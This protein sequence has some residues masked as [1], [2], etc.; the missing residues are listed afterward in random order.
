MKLKEM[1][2]PQETVI[3]ICTKNGPNFVYV[4]LAGEMDFETINRR[5]RARDTANTML[6]VC[7]YGD[8]KGKMHRGEFDKIISKF[9]DFTPVE[10]RDV[11]ET[12]PGQFEANSLVIKITGTEGWILYNPMLPPMKDVDREGAENLVAA[13]YKGLCAELITAYQ[14]EDTYLIERCEKEIRRD[15]YGL[16]DRPE[17]LIRECR[18]KARRENYRGIYGCI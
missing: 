12:Y 3:R 6:A 14:A 4:G 2:I 5:I 16:M 7:E 8:P 15:R 18:K 1:E 11:V 13:I 10:D 17:G 9:R